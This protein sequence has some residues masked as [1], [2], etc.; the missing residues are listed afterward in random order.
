MKSIT[1]ILSLAMLLFFSNFL[2]GQ[3][4][5]ID[6]ASV[7]MENKAELNLAIYSYK[8]LA[9]NVKTDF[10]SLQLILEET[11]NIQEKTPYSIN[12]IP[13]KSMTIKQTET[14]EKIIWENGVQ[15]LYQFNNQC[16]ITADNYLLQIQFNE[17]EVLISDSLL[18]QLMAVIDT[19]T[20]IQGRYA[21]TFNYSFEGLKL[22]HNKQY[23]DK[24]GQM[25]ML[26]LKGGVGVN[27]IKSEPVIDVSAEITFAFTKKGILKNQYFLSYNL[28]FDFMEES[29]VNLNGFLN[30]GYRN[31]LSNNKDKPNWLGVEVGY[32]VNSQGDLFGKNT[33]KLGVNWEL[34]RYVS[35]SPQL[36]MSDNFNQFYP[37][38]RIGFGF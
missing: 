24:N 25:D 19:T 14:G 1:R 3:K 34:G 26:M 10:S 8:N 22:I 18:T 32:L 6:S 30:L 13:N 33:F 29:T 11:K 9:E 20:N 27:L 28:L 21:T 15:T 2:S 36:Y 4:T 12:Y 35:V 31:N 37:A 17:L 23:D 7:R 16:T 5:T 38:I